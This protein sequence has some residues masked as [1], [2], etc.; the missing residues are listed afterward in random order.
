MQGVA[1]SL[2][3]FGRRMPY[4]ETLALHR[5]QPRLPVVAERLLRELPLLLQAV[6]ARGHLLL[7]NL[8]TVVDCLHTGIATLGHILPGALVFFT[9]P[10][11][12][13]LCD[14][15]GL[16]PALLTETLALLHQ[17]VAKLLALLPQVAADG[18]ERDQKR[19]AEENWIKRLHRYGWWMDSRLRH[20][21]PAGSKKKGAVAPLCPNNPCFCLTGLRLGRDRRQQGREQLPETGDGRDVHLLIG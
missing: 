8:M 17:I 2:A 5:L 7:N 19:E 20:S 3:A 13:L 12:D 4:A 10:A 1:Q 21:T 11:I 15:C 18:A 14:G 9:E 6:T 16:H